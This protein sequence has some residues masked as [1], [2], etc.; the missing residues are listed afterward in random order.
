MEVYIQ[1]DPHCV[2]ETVYTIGAHITGAA[3]H[4]RQPLPLELKLTA[5]F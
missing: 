5:W 3:T 1:G 2:T 4:F